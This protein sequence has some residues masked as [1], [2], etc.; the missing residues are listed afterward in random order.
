MEE[1]TNFIVDQN[2]CTRCGKCLNVC[3]GMVLSMEDGRPVMKPF[4]RFGRQT[5][6]YV[7]SILDGGFQNHTEHAFDFD[8]TDESEEST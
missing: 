5:F 7:Y 2:K 4:E 6:L 3:S 8:E 1:K